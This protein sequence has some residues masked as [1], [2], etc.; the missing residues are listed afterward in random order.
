MPAFHERGDPVRTG[1]SM[2]TT[3]D[4]QAPTQAQA[5]IDPL[6]VI[7][8]QDLRARLA[9]PDPGVQPVRDHLDRFV[10]RIRDEDWER[11]RQYLHEQ[12]ALP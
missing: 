12:R 2:E 5:K 8:P 10:H 3:T 11:I 9:A 1:C 6:E 7:L 4:A